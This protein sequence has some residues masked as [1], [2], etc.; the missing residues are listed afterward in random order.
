[1]SYFADAHE[2]YGTLGRML[3]IAGADADLGMQQADTV[4]RSVYSEP[5]SVIT[6][7]LRPGEAQVDF[8]DSDLEPE[9]VMSMRAD[10]A[11][12]FWL[13]EVNVPL[14]LARGEMQATGPTAKILRFVP[15]LAPVF[16][17]YRELLVEQGREDLAS[18]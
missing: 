10:V 2:V 4:V 17:R 18:A 1:M 7:S 14:A 8:G 15:L 6:I 5:D 12:R 3:E 11:H 16:P 13:G 9:I